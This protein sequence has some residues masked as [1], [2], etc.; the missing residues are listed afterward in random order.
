MKIL[1][2][3]R[4]GNANWMDIIAETEQTAR[5]I[6]EFKLP[7]IEKIWLLLYALIQ[8]DIEKLEVVDRLISMFQWM[9]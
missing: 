4:S 5:S 1:L 8:F 9:I 2:A 3:A 7:N 6:F